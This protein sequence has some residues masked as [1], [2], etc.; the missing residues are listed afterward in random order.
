[1]A[2]LHAWLLYHQGMMQGEVDHLRGVLE[3]DR[4]NHS[5]PQTPAQG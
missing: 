4:R 2:G 3:E 1:M 5:A